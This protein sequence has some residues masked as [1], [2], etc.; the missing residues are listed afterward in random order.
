MPPALSLIFADPYLS[1]AAFPSPTA[2]PVLP[3]AFGHTNLAPRASVQVD[4]DEEEEVICFRPMSQARGA[5]VEEEEKEVVLDSM[6][7]DLHLPGE[8]LIEEAINEESEE[9]KGLAPDPK[10]RRIAPGEGEENVKDDDEEEDYEDDYSDDDD[11]D[12]DEDYE[13]DEDEE[14]P[15]LKGLKRGSDIEEYLGGLFWCLKMYMEGALHSTFNI[16]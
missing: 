5:A 3:P 7:R 6:D 4:D 1:A 2:A 8:D 11:E 15:A 13:D 14:S 12:E 16:V 10:R 9:G